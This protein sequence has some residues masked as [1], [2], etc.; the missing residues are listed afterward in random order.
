MKITNIRQNII[1]IMII[2]IKERK[3]NNRG[4]MIFILTLFLLNKLTLYYKVAA[5]EHHDITSNL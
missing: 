3:N 1:I 4:H 2:I 5:V